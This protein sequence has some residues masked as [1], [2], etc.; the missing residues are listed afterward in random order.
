MQC[1][2]CPPD[3]LMR[4]LFIATGI[5][6]AAAILLVVKLSEGKNLLGATVTV[7]NTFIVNPT[8]LQTTGGTVHLQWQYDQPYFNGNGAVIQYGGFHCEVRNSAGVVVA[9]SPVT[10][11]GQANVTVTHSDTFN[12]SC[13][14]GYLSAGLWNSVVGPQ[15]SASVTVAAAP[16]SS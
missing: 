10:M 15:A 5:L 12:L 13:A 16:S 8:A 6:A 1:L 14:Y 4:R 7:H 3:S 9:S 11:D 2:R